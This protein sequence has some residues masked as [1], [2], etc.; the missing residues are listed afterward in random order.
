MKQT[1]SDANTLLLMEATALRKEVPPELLCMLP[2]EDGRPARAFTNAPGRR[3]I[4]IGNRV[5]Q[6]ALRDNAGYKYRQKSRYK[7][8]PAEIAK[9]NKDDNIA[10]EGVSRDL[11]NP[12]GYRS[13]GSIDVDADSDSDAA[14]PTPPK[15]TLTIIMEQNAKRVNIPVTGP[16][17]AQIVKHNK[18]INQ[19]LEAKFGKSP[20]VQLPQGR[21]GIASPFLGDLALDFNYR[22][23]TPQALR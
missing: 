5:R 22:K 6:N 2:R 10:L 17:K 14:R 8:D 7:Q 9:L 16:H 4:E 20:D 13:T 15:N 12:G 1:T 19:M 23:A 21:D 18:V 3:M 11:G